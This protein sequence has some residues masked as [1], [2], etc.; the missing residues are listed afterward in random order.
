M[1]Q[2]LLADFV[3]RL[4]RIKGKFIKQEQISFSL[5]T[6]Y[7]EGLY[8]QKLEVYA[9][10]TDIISI[11]TA[12]LNLLTGF[13]PSISSDVQLPSVLVFRPIRAGH[14]LSSS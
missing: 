14:L 3:I 2:L 12:C 10:R 1:L 13:S 7:R 6:K 4:V 11:S 9:S 5:I 8:L